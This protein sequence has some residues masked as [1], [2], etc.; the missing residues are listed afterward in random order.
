MEVSSTQ[1]LGNRFKGCL[2][3]LALGDALGGRFEGQTADW[4]ARRYP[5]PRSLLERPPLD[6]LHYTD[7]TQM[8]IAIAEALL[9]SQEIREDQLC[10]L[11]VANYEPYRGYG[12]GARAVLEA[13]QDG[14]DYRAMAANHFPGGSYGNGAAMRV[15]PIGLFFSDD[16]AQ[17]WQQ[18][19]L[20]ALPTH[21]HPLGIEGAQLLALAVALCVDGT[22]LDNTSFFGA[23][24]ARSESSAFR[25]K[26]ERAAQIRS[27][28]DLHA[29]GIGIAALES[30][31]TAMA[32][33]TLSPESYGNA[34]AQAVLL[35]GDTDTIAAMTGA[36]SGAFL[37]A[38][39]IPA[40]LVALLEDETKGRTYLES[41]AT[42]L[43]QAF[44][45]RTNG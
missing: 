15:A 5:T 37:G 21:V 7:D 41:L 32:C 28:E 16:L 22:T 45:V 14:G 40:H 31:V 6:R 12:R 25:E 11:F 36:L 23:L 35:G 19:R 9:E 24:L 42:K 18:A 33:F 39:A 2:L 38:D 20:S 30:V 10:R 26:L 17:V 44:L 1:T 34:V 29:L 43:H 8:T 27:P 4:I 3:G 13:M